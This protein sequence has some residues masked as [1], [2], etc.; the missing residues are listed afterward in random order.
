MHPRSTLS[1]TTCTAKP[2]PR[3]KAAWIA[4]ILPQLDHYPDTE[5]V[6][7]YTQQAQMEVDEAG[8]GRA[9]RPANTS[10]TK[11]AGAAGQTQ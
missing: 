6:P 8:A 2:G 10:G 5:T 4:P 1:P 7:T 3:D 9:S 11:A